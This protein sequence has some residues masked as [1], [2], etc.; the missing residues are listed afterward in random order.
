ME[1]KFYVSEDF[2]LPA[3]GCGQKINRKGGNCKG[4]GDK[5]DRKKPRIY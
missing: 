5:T 3:S 1:S 2:L 4:K